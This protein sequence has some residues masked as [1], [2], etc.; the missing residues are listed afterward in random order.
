MKYLRG[1]YLQGVRK[2]I[3]RRSAVLAAV[4]IAL[5]GSGLA[6]RAYRQRQKQ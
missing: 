1:E 4:S 6:A 2:A 3:T 5:V